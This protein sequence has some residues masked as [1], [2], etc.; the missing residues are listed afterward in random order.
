MEYATPSEYEESYPKHFW[1]E[2][3]A[4]SRDWYK[5]PHR[6]TDS[7]EAKLSR[8]PD[9]TSDWGDGEES[10]D[11]GDD[12]S[13]IEEEPP[14]EGDD[15]STIAEEPPDEGNEGSAK[16]REPAEMEDNQLLTREK[17][18]EDHENQ[19]NVDN[20][21]ENQVTNQTR[22]RRSSRNKS[23]VNYSKM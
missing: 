21:D 12:E 2:I 6:T 18:P 20:T 10:P 5:R 14:D 4:L 13:T 16:E 7:L 19:P 8:R 9:Q 23:V 1:G 11:E 3:V 17:S 15:E 22:E